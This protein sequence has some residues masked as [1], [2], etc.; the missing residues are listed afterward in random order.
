MKRRDFLR[1]AILTGATLSLAGGIDPLLA[2]VEG[3]ERPDLA[4][5]RGPLPERI[6]RAAVGELG[7]MGRFVSRGDI[8]V[9]KPNIG[10]DRTPEYAANT[11]P[12]VVAEL[13]RLAYEAGAKTVKVFDYPVNDPRRTYRQSGIAAAATAAGARVSFID[14]RKFRDTAVR[15]ELLKSWPLYTEILEADKVINVPIAK[16]H[17]IATLTLGMK[18]WMGVM[19]G[20]RGRIHQ[21]L[22]ESLVDIARV[23]RPS[24]IVLDAVRILVANGP[25]G[26]SL[27]DVRRLDTVVAGTDQVAVD[28]FGSTLFGLKH[29]ALGCVRIGHGSGLGNMNLSRLRVRRLTV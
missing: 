9:V 11:N 5:V 15:G 18:N 27:A 26:G 13:V 16:V 24:L 25:Q 19:G 12:G 6:T 29:D 17:G 23:V 14:E 21:R 20:W 2:L 1:K 10:W 3:A 28:A 7:G 8:V 22:D 4:V